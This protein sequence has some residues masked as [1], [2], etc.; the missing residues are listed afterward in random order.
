MPDATRTE[1]DSMGAVE[2]PAEALWGAQTQ[3]SLQNFDIADDR[4]PPELVHALARIKQ[5]AASVNARL[6]VISEPEREAIVTAA[7]AV[8]DAQHDDQ[9]PLRVW[10]TGSGTQTNM[11]VNEVISNLAARAAGE[12]LGSHRP[13]HP[14]SLIHI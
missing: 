12:P 11:N 7:A 6:G 4:V 9:F 8:A 10:Q 3:R 13:V 2:V 1:H 14:L 5:A